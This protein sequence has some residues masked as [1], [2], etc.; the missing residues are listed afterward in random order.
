MISASTLL[1]ASCLR[2]RR[3]W[4]VVAK[5]SVSV[6]S[7]S[8]MPL[9]PGGYPTAGLLSA[10]PERP[11]HGQV[12]DLITGHPLITEVDL[13]LPFGSTVYRH[14]RTYGEPS[15]LAVENGK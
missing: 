14:V 10:F 6:K 1:V 15:A 13:E 7:C 8:A 4:G 9:L 12:M 11:M 3:A 5:S 2:R